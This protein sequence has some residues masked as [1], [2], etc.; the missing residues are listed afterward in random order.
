MFKH[1]IILNLI[2]FG[3]ELFVRDIPGNQLLRQSLRKLFHS[4]GTKI[5][6]SVRVFNVFNWGIERPGKC[7]PPIISCPGNYLKWLQG[8]TLLIILGLALCQSHLS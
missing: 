2:G 5:L 6:W 1:L 7:H 4:H 3:E 8:A